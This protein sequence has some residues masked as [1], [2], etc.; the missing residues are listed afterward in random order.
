MYPALLK[1]D[2]EGRFSSSIRQEIIFRLECAEDTNARDNQLKE[3]VNV[4]GSRGGELL[5]PGQGPV[6]G[7][8]D[9]TN[10][11]GIGERLIQS[12]E[13]FKDKKAER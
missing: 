8:K 4:I 2:I 9:R 10:R 7:I 3:K 6:S 13:E 12:S 11:G 5:R 1:A